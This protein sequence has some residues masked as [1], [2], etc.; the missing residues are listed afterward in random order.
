MYIKYLN[1]TRT[2]MCLFAKAIITAFICHRLN[3]TQMHSNKWSCVLIFASFWCICRALKRKQKELNFNM[4]IKG[5]DFL[6][7]IFLRM[8]ARA[9]LINDLHLSL[10]NSK[11]SWSS[12]A[13]VGTN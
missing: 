7:K 10:F 8:R 5:N 11:S 12:A 6:E 1:D 3:C 9:N 2:R 4:Q 13:N